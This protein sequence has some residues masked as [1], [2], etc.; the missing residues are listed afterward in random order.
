M[1]LYETGTNLCSSCISNIQ[2]VMINYGRKSIGLCCEDRRHT[3]L[4]KD[5]SRCTRRS[6][7]NMYMLLPKTS[8]Q[9]FMRIPI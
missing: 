2:E 9:L 5:V 3:D 6:A 1:Y 8:S 7:R 4:L